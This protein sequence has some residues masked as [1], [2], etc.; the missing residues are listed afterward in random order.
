M[1]PANKLN[2]K[3]LPPLNICLDNSVFGS[4]IKITITLTFCNNHDDSS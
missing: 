3:P 2:G 4:K 1:V